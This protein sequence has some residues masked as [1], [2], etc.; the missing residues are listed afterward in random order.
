MPLVCGKVAWLVASI[1]V[2]APS[3]GNHPANSLT[4]A[5]R[6]LA[7]DAGGRQ[8]FRAGCA[9]R[10]G[11]ALKLLDAENLSRSLLF[12]FAFCPTRLVIAY[13]LSWSRSRGPKRVMRTR[14]TSVLESVIVGFLLFDRVQ[15]RALFVGVTL[16]CRPVKSG[17]LR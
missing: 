9:E 10:E 7:T 11:R 5:P 8:G 13:A 15:Y 17:C 14:H 16:E 3:A 4:G 1:R 2:P 12:F 6:T